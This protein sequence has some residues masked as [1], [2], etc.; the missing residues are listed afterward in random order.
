L[1]QPAPQPTQSPEPTPSPSVTPEAPVLTEPSSPDLPV[2][3]GPTFKLP[4]EFLYPKVIGDV[5]T[6]EAGLPECAIN[7]PTVKYFSA[8]IDPKSTQASID[9][10]EL[11]PLVTNTSMI[12]TLVIMLTVPLYTECKSGKSSNVIFEIELPKLKYFKYIFDMIHKKFIFENLSVSPA[13]AKPPIA[14]SFVANRNLPGGFSAGSELIEVNIGTDGIPVISSLANVPGVDYQIKAIAK[15]GVIVTAYDGRSKNSTAHTY[16]VSNT[17]WTLLSTKTIF[18]EPSVVSTDLKTLYGRRVK[19]AANS[20]VIFAQ[21]LKTGNTPI[22]FDAAKHGGGFICG[23]VAD[24]T[25]KFGYFT[26]LTKKRTDIYQIDL[27]NGKMKKLGTTTAGAC[28]DATNS[29]GDFIAKFVNPTTLETQE[30]DLIVIS[31]KNPKS[32]RHIEIRETFM[33]TG[34]HS[35]I[36]FGEYVM[37]WNSTYDPHL[38]GLEKHEGYNFDYLDPETLDG[39]KPLH[40]LQYICNLPLTWQ[41]DPKRPSFAIAKY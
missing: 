3:S 23:V 22:Y 17:K 32:Y 24:P 37:G 27:G 31:K 8:L 6:F 14:I 35:L 30:G 20:T 1:P 38:V 29:N 4:L 41:T 7:K 12:K 36:P 9:E 21:N 15:N 39:P 34:M 28:I 2:L 5:L 33:Q 40:F 25:F 26:H 16:L 10:L 11:A 18:V 19:D 13:I